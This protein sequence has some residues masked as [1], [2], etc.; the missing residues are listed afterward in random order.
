MSFSHLYH[1]EEKQMQSKAANCVSVLEQAQHS[2]KWLS[3]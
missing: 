1:S 3:L 2:G